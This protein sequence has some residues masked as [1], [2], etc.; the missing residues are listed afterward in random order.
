MEPLVGKGSPALSCLGLEQ[1]REYPAAWS[2]LQTCVC[3]C[4]SITVSETS[5]N[6]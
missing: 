5:S 6:F 3:S 2:L 4:R 1:H